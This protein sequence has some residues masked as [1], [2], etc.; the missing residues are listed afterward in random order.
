MGGGRVDLGATKVKTRAEIWILKS[1]DRVVVCVV[2]VAVKLVC[3]P[4][5]LSTITGDAS[6]NE[7]LVVMTNG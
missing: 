4:P 5:R 7:E 1:M 3:P 6:L 2:D